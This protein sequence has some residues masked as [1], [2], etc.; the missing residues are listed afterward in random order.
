MGFYLLIG[1]KF[2][3]NK[4]HDVMCIFLKVQQIYRS[5]YTTPQSAY[6]STTLE[7]FLGPFL[8]VL[9]HISDLMCHSAEPV[10][11]HVS[12]AQSGPPHFIMSLY[13]VTL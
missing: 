10:G 12:C 4:N 2:K 3:D 13:F 1:A 5:L 8:V 7:P 6:I 9:S 11:M